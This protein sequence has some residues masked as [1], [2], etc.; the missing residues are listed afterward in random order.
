[1]SADPSMPG[2]LAGAAL[3]V[4]IS[5][6]KLGADDAEGMSRQL[7]ALTADQRGDQLQRLERSL[8]RLERVNLQT[9]ALLQKLVNAVKKPDDKPS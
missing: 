2:G 7:A 3:D 8:L 4:D 1:A 5:Q 6:V 9:L